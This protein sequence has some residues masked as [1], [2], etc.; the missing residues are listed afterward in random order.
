MKDFS[1]QFEFAAHV[2]L[3]FGEGLADDLPSIVTGRMG[4]DRVGVVVDGGLLDASEPARRLIAGLEDA[5][6]RC[7]VH[8]YR[9][10]HEPSY[11]FLD[12]V[13]EEFTGGDCPLV[14][15]V[16]GVGGGSAMDT[17]KGVATLATNPGPALDYRG[18]PEDLNPTLPVVAVPST[19]G[20][21]SEVAFNAV[22]TD[23]EEGKK[24]GINSRHNYPEL[25]VLD[26]RI[27][28][29]APRSVW[30]S[31]GAD[32]LVHAL[33]S[34]ASP[35]A[36][37][38][39]RLFSREAFRLLTSGLSRLLEDDSDLR[40]WGRAQVGASVAMLGLS[41]ATSGPTGAL[42]YHLGATFGVAHGVAG[43][44]FLGPVMALNHRA[45]WHGYA[46]LHDLL[47]GDRRGAG[48]DGAEAG[49][50]ER[51]RRVVE[52]VRE[53]LAEMG[54]PRSVR[55]VGVLPDD[56]GG[57]VEFAT[58]TAPA[59]MELNPVPVGEA[60]LWS[61][62]ESVGLERAPGRAGEG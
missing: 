44:I 4:H 37:P 16:V 3:R 21:G 55:K 59:A 54:L 9:E 35:R 45:G 31:A 1:D 5:A 32:A 6:V 43:G 12:R 18:F 19:A 27:V 61:V 28:A 29:A 39:S 42:S 8:E 10:P 47:P 48:G 60:E 13:R 14:D 52:A 56:A 15:C 30:S 2:D 53:L 23:R 51:S 41:N 62:L 17:A 33:E 36:T 25:A 22:F 46:E 20:T 49:R 58:E 11:G 50:A 24:L 40:A 57:F 38:L 34:F 26:P 7:V